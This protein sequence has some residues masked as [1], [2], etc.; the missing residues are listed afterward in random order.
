MV[1]LDRRDIEEASQKENARGDSDNDRKRPDESENTH[2]NLASR[3]TPPD[4]LNSEAS[5]VDPEISPIGGGP[6]GA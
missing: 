4:M 1:F 6:S 2:R 3:L 5:P